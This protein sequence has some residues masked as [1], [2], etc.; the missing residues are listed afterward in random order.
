MIPQTD[1]DD[2]K[3]PFKTV[4]VILGFAT[5]FLYFTITTNSKIDNAIAVATAAKDKADK[6]EDKLS[7]ANISLITYKV[8]QIS[9]SVNEIKD[10]LKK[11]SRNR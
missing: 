1:I 7:A 5:Q 9:S 3:F 8:D 2:V 4:L 10:E 6:A 11:Q